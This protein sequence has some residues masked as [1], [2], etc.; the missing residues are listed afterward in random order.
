MPARKLHL[1]LPGNFSIALPMGLTLFPSPT[2]VPDCQV[3]AR[4]SKHLSNR[5]ENRAGKGARPNRPVN[6]AWGKKALVENIKSLGKLG[7]LIGYFGKNVW[8]IPS[9]R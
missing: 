7:M 8:S 3:G 6:L 4:K 5:S 9:P 1:C 2:V